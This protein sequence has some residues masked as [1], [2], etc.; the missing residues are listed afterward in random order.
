MS[1]NATKSFRKAERITIIASRGYLGTARDGI[2][3]CVGPFN[4]GRIRQVRI[5]PVPLGRVKLRTLVLR[6]IDSPPYPA[7]RSPAA[8]TPMARR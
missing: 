4:G 8:F 2:P 5:L 1:W 3:G 6:H 7:L